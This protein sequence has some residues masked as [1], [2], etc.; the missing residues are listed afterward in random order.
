MSRG[1]Y[2]AER[3]AALKGQP[4]SPK[5]PEIKGRAPDWFDFAVPR[6]ASQPDDWRLRKVLR[7]LANGGR[8][9]LDRAKSTWYCLKASGGKLKI[10][11]ALMLEI[12]RC[13]FIDFALRLTNWGRYAA[14]A[15]R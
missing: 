10:K 14:E 11:W 8:L 4:L 9:V 6:K 12:R 13:E 7:A 2:R 15:A 5:P 3:N 1:Q